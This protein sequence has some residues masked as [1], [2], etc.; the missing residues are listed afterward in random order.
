[1]RL[2]R[3]R[4]RNFRQI[5][6][7][8]ALI[9]D[10]LVGLVGENG[11]GKCLPGWV[12]V[13]D[14][15]AGE[16]VAIEQF[17]RERRQ[18]VLGYVDGQIVPTCVSEWHETGVKP[19]V[20]LTFANGARWE[21]AATHPMMTPNG[22]K[23]AGELEE[24]DWVAEI[25]SL[26]GVKY[27]KLTM[28]EAYLL[29][30]LT[31]DGTVTK[32][33]LLSAISP[34]VIELFG[35]CVEAIFP[36]C[37]IKSNSV[38]NTHMIISDL[39]AEQRRSAAL[40]MYDE[41]E[42]AGIDLSVVLPN[43]NNFV[44][45]LRGEVGFYEETFDAIE[46]QT[47]LD[48]WW[49]RCAFAPAAALR[50]WA[51]QVG[52]YGHNAQT[53][54]IKSDFLMQPEDICGAILA[55]LWMT[56]GYISELRFHTDKPTHR[57]GSEIS[58][59]TASYDLA[60]DVRLL[61][62]RLDII[63]TLRRK[64]VQ[65]KV[66]WDVRIPGA[67]YSRFAEK[68]P[69]VGPKRERLLRHL[70]ER[71]GMRSNS[72]IDAMPPAFYD[73]L[74]KLSTS[75]SDQRAWRVAKK[76]GGMSRRVFAEFGGE[77][78]GLL[79]QNKS[80]TTVKSVRLS[81][82]EVPTFDVTL[83]SEEHVY[84]ADT[85]LV[86]NSGLSEA[87]GIALHGLDAIKEGTNKEDLIRDDTQE[88]VHIELEFSLGEHLYRVVR[89][90]EA[91]SLNSKADLYRDGGK[92]PIS[93]NADPVTAK[94]TE[95][96]GSLAEFRMSRFVRQK[97]LDEL[98]SLAPAKR[99]QM[100][101]KLMGVDA[102]ETALADL[103]KAILD[104]DKTIKARQAVLPDMD[105]LGDRVKEINRRRKQIV[106]DQA[107][108][109]E[110]SLAL[111]ALAHSAEVALDGFNK[112]AERVAYSTMNRQ[113]ATEALTEIAT[114][115]TELDASD[116]RLAQVA[117]QMA[118]A[119]ESLDAAQS[120]RAELSD[121]ARIGA[122]RDSAAALRKQRDD[123]DA[124]LTGL[125]AKHQE[126]VTK[127]A[128]ETGLVKAAGQAT[129]D[130]ER[131][132]RDNA[133][134]AAARAEIK[135]RAL[136]L[137]ENGQGF[138]VDLKRLDE[139]EIPETCRS[140]GQPISDPT[141]YQ[142]HL[143]SNLAQVQSELADIT[144]QGVA[145]KAREESSAAAGAAAAARASQTATELE[146]VREAAASARVLAATIEQREIEQKSVLEQ[147]AE[148]EA[149]PYNK[150]RHDTL[151]SEADAVP[152]L[153]SFVASARGELAERERNASAR[154]RE[155]ARKSENEERC[156]VA[157][158]EMAKAGYV[159][160]DH[161]AVKVAA[162]QAR[163]AATASL[164]K[165]SSLE[166]DLRVADSEIKAAQESEAHFIATNAEIRTLLD[167]RADLK[168]TLEWMDR[169]K[170]SLIGRLRPALSRKAS[171]LLAVLTDGRYT[172]LTLTADYDIL[173]GMAG[174]QKSV[175]RASGGEEDLL[176]LCLRLAVSELINETT[177]V[178]RTFLVLDEIL[179]AQSMKRE[180]A[181]M[182]LM[183]KLSAH[184]GQILMIAH[185]PAAQDRFESVIE[186][187]LDEATDTSTVFY[188]AS[189][190]TGAIQPAVA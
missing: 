129:A 120:H 139:G 105:K 29:G 56:D 101:L 5:V 164:L 63:S 69:L 76:H 96:V 113:I 107:L 44:R 38:G 20:E 163:E 58:Y 50:K 72:S 175:G 30:L 136:R 173:F 188:P 99:K 102:V 149:L 148:A 95:L 85:F 112:S 6:E 64:V 8:D 46:E 165:V 151:S 51:K 154:E 141:I 180:L 35:L 144:A 33:V 125:R 170:T 75:G 145:A 189:L 103:R 39:K 74:N 34:E 16:A 153:L 92:T 70:I 186:V 135:A 54:R 83:D 166:G 47:R 138:R 52:L 48:L 174:K 161:E 123:L 90:I 93:S 77:K 32:Q 115:L 24:G 150:D 143:K 132:A 86:H 21:T 12:R 182:D 114:R 187:V 82:R 162:T 3:L 73:L 126:L 37:H 171:R 97:Q 133:T 27:Q 79:A 122:L 168:V 130:S 4:L 18:R 88:D 158:A 167:D 147:I 98:S 67:M 42:R 89:T 118:A 119:Q 146:S 62:L 60:S 71:D 1:M 65:G 179:G 127:A 100:I 59:S 121:L 41:M 155:L 128:K 178:G 22:F 84:V 172:D 109:Q 61:L 169:F 80:W 68:I 36:G 159:P 131:A 142:E 10:G 49:A 160:A 104:L 81:G 57:A 190:N 91:K 26:P 183:P 28:E 15:D 157:E 11:A 94:I 140:C 111:R 13:Y 110:E 78:T 7:C 25:R 137:Q 17:V 31:G 66:Y 55:G 23:P 45:F 108:A 9:P 184:F 176:N 19:T 53:K 177:G 2:I 106:A 134:A 152:G 117:V 40:R 156:S 185:K 14:P 124:T 87:I 116:I 43:K 181:I